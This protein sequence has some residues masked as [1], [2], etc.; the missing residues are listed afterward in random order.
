[1]TKTSQSTELPPGLSFEKAVAALQSV[2][3]PSAE[4]RHNVRLI[5]KLG[6]RRQFDVVIRAKAAGHPIL[7]VIECRDLKG[8]VDSPQINS[9]ADK[10][11]NINANLVLCFSRRGFTK[12]ALE[13]ARYHGIGTFSLLKADHE[14]KGLTFGQTWYA[15][16]SRWG[17]FRLTL[18]L[19]E[20]TNLGPWDPTDLTVDGIRV[21][22]WVTTVLFG[23][24]ANV[25]PA[26]W[27]NLWLRFRDPHQCLVGARPVLVSA[28]Q[29][30]AELVTAHKARRILW[31]G[32]AMYNWSTGQFTIPPQGHLVSQAWSGDFSDWD[33]FEGPLPPPTPGPFLE[34]RFSIFQAP[35]Q[36]PRVPDTLAA[37]VDVSLE[38]PA[39]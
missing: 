30:Q 3:D 12:P 13:L 4:V 29:A 26:G 23:T 39:A 1:M 21:V 20:L 16:I 14:T 32:Q 37:L 8:P 19:A 15:T 22:D 36:L 11:R 7:G 33:D 28:I 24:Y 17:A 10:A 9:L 6:H 18:H 25:A 2:L 31:A 27:Y 38:P 34:A 5:D 35:T